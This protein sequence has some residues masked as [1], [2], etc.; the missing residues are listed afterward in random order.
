MGYR[1]IGLIV[2][3]I[4]GVMGYRTLIVHM[5]VGCDGVCVILTL[6]K[7]LGR[8]FFGTGDAI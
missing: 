7:T 8:L 5:V 4:G 1:L 3:G 6:K 2:H